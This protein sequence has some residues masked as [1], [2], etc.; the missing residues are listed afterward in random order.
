MI[1]LTCVDYS[2]WFNAN[3]M[4]QISNKWHIGLCCAYNFSLYDSKLA[5]PSP[6]LPSITQ[7]SSS[8]FGR[9]AACGL[10][11]LIPSSNPRMNTVNVMQPSRSV[12]G[13]TL[14]ISSNIHTAKLWLVSFSYWY[15]QLL[16]G[17]CCLLFTPIIHGNFTGILAT[18]RL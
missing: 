12:P 11:C 13:C 1:H 5:L 14:Y 10:S 4:A 2:C 17:I 7:H 3:I 18:V 16:A 8:V 15:F 6:S 9:R